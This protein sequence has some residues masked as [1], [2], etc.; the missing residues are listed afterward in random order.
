MNN[1]FALSG[2]TA[3]EREGS[4]ESRAYRRRS[5]VENWRQEFSEEKQAVWEVRS[6]QEGVGC[7][8]DCSHGWPRGNDMETR[9]PS[10]CPRGN[11][12][13]LNYC[14]GS[15]HFLKVFI[16]DFDSQNVLQL[17]PNEHILINFLVAICLLT[18]MIC[19]ITN[20]YLFENLAIKI[21]VTASYQRPTSALQFAFLWTF[22]PIWYVPLIFFICFSYWYPNWSSS[23]SFWSHLNWIPGSE[24]N[25]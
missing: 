22:Q 10:W 16:W 6:D 2:F 15:L 17:L 8:G 9:H 13:S 14:D 21:N 1:N 18:C 20:K 19:I 4:E 25:T 5:A 3:V 24:Q 23:L 12:F 7:R 11:S